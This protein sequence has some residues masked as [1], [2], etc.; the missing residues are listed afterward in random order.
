MDRSSSAVAESAESHCMIIDT[1]AHTVGS[2]A[3]AARAKKSSVLFTPRR[4]TIQSPPL[5][6]S[7]IGT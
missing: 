3:G 6:G 4:R 7:P 5:E 1:G 2:L